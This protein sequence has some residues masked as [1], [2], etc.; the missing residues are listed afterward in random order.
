MAK[1][2]CNC[3]A[4]VFETEDIL[5]D[6]YICHCSICRRATGSTGIAVSIVAKR[7]F[8]WLT[9]EQHIRHWRKPD[10]DWHNA[11]CEICG[12][13]LPAE[14]DETHMYIPVSALTSGDNTLNN[15][16]HLHTESAAPWDATNYD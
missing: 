2:Q 8:R 6:V 5:R 10:H 13:P 9:G 3:G 11:F 4:V 12:S 7:T 14:N 15:L 16:V 1:G